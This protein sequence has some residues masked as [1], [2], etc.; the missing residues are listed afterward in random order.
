[1]CVFVRFDSPHHAGI[2]LEIDLYS[3]IS[4]FTIDEIALLEPKSCN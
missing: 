4:D 2:A 1:M 3:R